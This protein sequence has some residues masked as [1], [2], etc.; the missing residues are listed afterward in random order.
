MLHG[1]PPA[2]PEIHPG[3]CSEAAFRA[4]IEAMPEADQSFA[5]ASYANSLRSVLEAQGGMAAN[6]NPES[7]TS[8]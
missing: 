2:M 3:S 1:E 7:I 6:E 4:R 8:P 5:L